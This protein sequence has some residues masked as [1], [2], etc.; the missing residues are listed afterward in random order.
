MNQLVPVV[1]GFLLTTV[2]GGLL[3]FLLQNRSW[4]HQHK[5][6]ASEQ[7]RQRRLQ[8][9]EQE[10][11]EAVQ[12][13]DEISR[14]MDKRLYRLRL[15]YWSLKEESDP[16][17]RSP[18]AEERW[19]E[20]RQV[21]Y[22]WNDSVNRNLALL[23]RYFGEKMRLRLDN[24]VGSTFV[25]LGRKV[26]QWWKSGTQPSSDLER[27]LREL[28]NMVYHFN[29]EMIIAIQSGSVGSHILEDS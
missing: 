24:A 19:K 3:G 21:L 16:G 22:E 27:Q 23:Y 1:A 5:V 15:V 25:A 6:L 29:L 10:R 26:E 28:S 20:Y 13:F 12:I 18:A 14:L 11:K 7:E 4:E 8:I 17:K 9:A 2:I